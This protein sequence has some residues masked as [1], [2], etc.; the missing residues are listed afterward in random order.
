MSSSSRKSH[1]TPSFLS[2]TRAPIPCPARPALPRCDFR[3]PGRSAISEMIETHFSML[4][5]GAPLGE[6]SRSPAPAGKAKSTVVLLRRSFPPP[7]GRCLPLVNVHPPALPHHVVVMMPS[8]IHPTEPFLGSRQ[9]HH[10]LG[11]Q[12][13][14][15]RRLHELA[16][17]HC[18]GGGADHSRHEDRTP[19]LASIAGA[20]TP[21]GKLRRVLTVVPESG[22]GDDQAAGGSSA[23]LLDE[24]VR[25]GVPGGCWPRPCNAR[26]TTT[27]PASP[28]NAT[29]TAAGWWCAATTSPPGRSP[30]PG[31]WT[32]PRVN[33]RR[34]EPD[35]ENHRS[36][37][38]V[39]ARSVN[40]GLCPGA[41][42]VPAC[43]PGS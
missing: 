26:S 19:L 33:D 7:A 14:R 39:P 13:H 9:Q 42:P 17:A 37:A 11:H 18:S 23:S 1:W 41:G 10:F 36:A 15:S 38:A 35:T 3:C 12:F 32:A 28:T 30:T 16:T 4:A 21:V 6:T 2:T 40:R 8:N 20:A 25:Q 24:I 43:S 5:A 31:P 34:V 22:A 29:T 27:S